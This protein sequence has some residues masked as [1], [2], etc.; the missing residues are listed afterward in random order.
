MSD[1]I[2]YVHHFVFVYVIK[3]FESNAGICLIL[4]KIEGILILKLI[5]FI[6]NN[7]FNSFLTGMGE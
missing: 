7:F 1:S 4:H 5:F 2:T 6:T 3:K